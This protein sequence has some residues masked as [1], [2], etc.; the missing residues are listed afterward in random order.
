MSAASIA[1][2]ARAGVADGARESGVAWAWVSRRTAPPLLW[3]PHPAY[4]SV[5]AGRAAPTA[6]ATHRA[7]EQ[8]LV[9]FDGLS[10]LSESKGGGGAPRA[11]TEARP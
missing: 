9:G 4:R 5:V 10:T 6:A 8:R 3:A 7:E 1:G 11:L 2:E